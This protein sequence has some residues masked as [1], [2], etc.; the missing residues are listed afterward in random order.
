ML[1]IEVSPTDQKILLD[2]ID[3][4]PPDVLMRQQLTTDQRK[5]LDCIKAS[6][7][8]LKDSLS[9]FFSGAAPPRW[10]DDSWNSV[11]EAEVR[12][13]LATYKTFW[14]GWTQINQAVAKCGDDAIA[15]FPDSP[16]EL[17]AL[18]L[19]LRCEEQCSKI[20]NGGSI[21]IRDSASIL[22]GTPNP[23]Q[24]SGSAKKRAKRTKEYATELN[25]EASQLL[26]FC[27]KAIKSRLRGRPNLKR[28]IK[29]LE[30]EQQRYIKTIAK[31]L[32]KKSPSGGTWSN[33]SFRQN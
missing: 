16:G 4:L 17:L 2:T 19:E 18:Y 31:A 32:R 12:F 3:D 11:V 14:F 26:N 13:C 29:E 23:D 6:H 27:I 24:K 15:A 10:C 28:D 9:A 21:S 5:H 22:R 1:N 8:D 33:G 30:K 7:Q 25:T 20:L